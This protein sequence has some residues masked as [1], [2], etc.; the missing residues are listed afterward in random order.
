MYELTDNIDQPLMDLYILAES[1]I[2]GTTE[3]EKPY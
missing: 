2:R 3:V 1:D